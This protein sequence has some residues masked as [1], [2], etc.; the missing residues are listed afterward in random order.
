MTRMLSIAMIGT[1]IF[2]IAWFAWFVVAET[3]PLQ[4]AVPC[5]PLEIDPRHASLIEVG[6]ARYPTLTSGF[7]GAIFVVAGIHGGCSK[8]SMIVDYFRGFITHR[9]S[10]CE[11]VP[12]ISKFPDRDRSSPMRS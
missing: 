2:A 9:Q 4:N 7:D 12:I 1:L 10:S 6:A 8:P 11:G 3:E 5:E